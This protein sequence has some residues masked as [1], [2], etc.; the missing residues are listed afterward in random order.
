MSA[1]TDPNQR[2]EWPDVLDQGDIPETFGITGPFFQKIG[3]RKRNNRDAK[4]LVT[5][6][7]AQTGVGKSNLCDFLGYALDTTDA[8]FT[9]DKVFIDPKAFFTAYERLEKGS[10][11]VLE[12]A[13]QIDSRRFMTTENVES[14]QVWQKGRVR[15]IIALLNL[16]SAKMIDKRM[17]E[18]CDFWINVE[19]RGR[20]KVY[21][22]KIHR[23][24][25]SVYYEA[26][27]VLHWPNMDGSQTFREMD[28]L[29]WDHIDGESSGTWIRKDEMQE[30]VEQ[31]VKE[32]TQN[33][34]N[35]FVTSVYGETDLTAKEVA[36][37]NAV[38]VSPSHIRTIANEDK[39]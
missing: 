20:A 5:A 6:D 16:P 13:E 21:E 18:L 4:I 11:T 12:E 22:K 39:T 27:Q 19:I 32:T 31:R 15:E 2:E 30:K 26:V 33:L 37:L 7:N 36:E 14:S 17:E 24:K 35:K 29:K 3:R 8:G 25:Q 10:A 38:E 28:R 34:R 1:V 9:D 23:T